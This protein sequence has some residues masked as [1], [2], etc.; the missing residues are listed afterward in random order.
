MELVKAKSYDELVQENKELK[1][2]IENFENDH[3]NNLT[4]MSKKLNKNV[5]GKNMDEVAQEISLMRA[6]ILD[7]FMMAYL[8]ETG[9]K[10]NEVKMVHGTNSDGYF[11]LY[12]VK[13]TKIISLHDIQDV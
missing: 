5:I 3:V 11:E 13:N 10:P 12:F 7:H 1:E 8:A 2:K 9:L 6:K 4:A